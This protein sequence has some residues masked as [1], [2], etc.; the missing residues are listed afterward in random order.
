MNSVIVIWL[1]LAEV[2][3]HRDVSD[4]MVGFSKLQ[5]LLNVTF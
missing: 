3:I 4:V 2:I 5:N 1:S